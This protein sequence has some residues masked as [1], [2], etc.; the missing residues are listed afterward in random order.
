MNISKSPELK[1]LTYFLIE[2]L[3]TYKA[4]LIVLYL[5]NVECA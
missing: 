2:D 5:E 3:V 4:I 1:L